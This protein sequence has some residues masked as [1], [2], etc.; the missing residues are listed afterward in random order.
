MQLHTGTFGHVS[1]ATAAT[2]AM[3]SVEEANEIIM[4]RCHYAPKNH[5]PAYKLLQGYFPSTSEIIHNPGT[6][7]AL[8]DM[9]QTNREMVFAL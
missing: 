3:E 8:S 9:F 6:F 1:L 5:L 7:K 2:A 4:L